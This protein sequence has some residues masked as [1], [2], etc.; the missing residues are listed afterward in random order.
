MAQLLAGLNTVTGLI[1]FF[2][3][4]GITNWVIFANPQAKVFPFLIGILLLGNAVYLAVAK[5]EF[6]VRRS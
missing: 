3:M 2:A 4:S 1:L 5:G 6:G